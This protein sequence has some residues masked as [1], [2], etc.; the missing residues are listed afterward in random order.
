MMSYQYFSP[1][2]FFL[3]CPTDNW[4]T[5]F[6]LDC[7]FLPICSEHNLDTTCR[8]NIR[9][10]KVLF[11]ICFWNWSKYVSWAKMLICSGYKSHW[12]GS[13]KEKLHTQLTVAI[14]RSQRVVFRIIFPIQKNDYLP[15][16]E[17]LTSRPHTPTWT[18]S[19]GRWCSLT[20]SAS[21]SNLTNRLFPHYML[22]SLVTNFTHNLSQTFS[23]HFRLTNLSNDLGLC[24]VR[25]L[26]TFLIL[27]IFIKIKS[28]FHCMNRQPLS[29]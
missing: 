17:R 6:L 13:F 18:S 16:D 24:V 27:K 8:S 5:K 25:L 26:V 20:N 3:R 7:S 22:H 10:S 21:L 12:R 1:T 23:H 15:F 28:T 9:K 11:Y 19:A 14:I 2:R 29:K 4:F